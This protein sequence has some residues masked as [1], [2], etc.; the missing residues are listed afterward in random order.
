MGTLRNV[1]RCQAQHTELR[2]FT[3]LRTFSGYDV[4][5]LYERWPCYRYRTS[6]YYGSA[7]L[8]AEFWPSQPLPSIFFYPRQ[9]SSSLALLTSVNIF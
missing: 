6:S 5:L 1:G 9:E 7:T 4:D 8:S 3:N 2:L